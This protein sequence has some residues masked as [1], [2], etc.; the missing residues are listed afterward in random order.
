[1]IEYKIKIA[2]DNT[3]SKNTYK[4]ARRI[5]NY[6][7]KDCFIIPKAGDYIQNDNNEVEKIEWVMYANNGA[8]IL[9]L[10]D[11]K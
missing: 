3:K 9:Y 7:F 8:I 11:E 5:I 10:E 2:S 4:N 1:M 6:L